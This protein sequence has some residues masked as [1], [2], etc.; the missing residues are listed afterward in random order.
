MHVL[1]LRHRHTVCPV[2]HSG[3]AIK[4]GGGGSNGTGDK[5][6]RVQHDKHGKL[7]YL[8]YNGIA[9]VEIYAIP[10]L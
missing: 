2:V 7:Q 10:M 4:Q 6:W 1:L 3:N 5:A 9:G 8:F